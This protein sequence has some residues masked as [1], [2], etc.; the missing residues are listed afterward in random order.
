M[1]LSKILS[2][3]QNV[4]KNAFFL[5]EKSLQ[6][7]SIS[8][9]MN[10]FSK[11]IGSST[12]SCFS[13]PPGSRCITAVSILDSPPPNLGGAGLTPGDQTI[14]Y[15][16]IAPLLILNVQTHNKMYKISF[17]NESHFLVSAVFW[18]KAKRTNKKRFKIKLLHCAL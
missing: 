10:I 14:R 16:T 8:Y 4:N 5:F 11:V 7:I 15:H 18:V 1:F 9:Q 3:H 2:F 6:I 13:L 12:C 17:G